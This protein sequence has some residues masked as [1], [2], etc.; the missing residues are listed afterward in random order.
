[1]ILN[2]ASTKT[3]AGTVIHCEVG[4]YI[5]AGAIIRNYFE[6]MGIDVENS[7]KNKALLLFIGNDRSRSMRTV[8]AIWRT[9]GDSLTKR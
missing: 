7:R 8:R 3:F 6:L 9:E 5:I 1:M 2:C 4:A